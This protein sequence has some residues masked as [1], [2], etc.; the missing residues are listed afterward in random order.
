VLHD[1]QPESNS[2]TAPLVD[3]YRAW[4]LEKQGATADAQACWK[5]AANADPGYCF[6]ARLEEI[7][8]L[9][10][11][12]AANPQDTLAQYLLGNLFYDRKRY[13]EAIQLWEQSANRNPGF[14]TVWRN[15][16]VAYFNCM[17]DRLRAP[18]SAA[19]AYDRALAC[20]PHDA[21]LLYERDQLRK[22]MNKPP[23][24]RLEKL[25]DRLDLVRQ[26]DDLT[27]ELCALYNQTG[28]HDAAL[29]LLMSRHFQPWEG[30]EG[31][32]LGQYVRTRLA[33]GRSAVPENPQDA[34]MHFQAA[35][36]PPQNLGETKHLLSNQSDI[37]YWLGV[38]LE[39]AGDPS[40]ARHYWSIAASIQGDF[41]EMSVR[42]YS[43]MSYYSILSLCRLGR[44]TE[45][46]ER[47]AGL[48][49][50]SESLSKRA[51]T[52]DYFATSLPTMLLFNDDLNARQ[53]IQSKVLRAQALF[54][55][56]RGFE[57]VQLLSE[58]LGQDASHQL[59]ADLLAELSRPGDAHL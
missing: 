40:A 37:H 24:Q 15:L 22:R 39:A 46:R 45:A 6:P 10:R 21:R 54:A 43:E 56:H 35:L 11:A 30:G 38:A 42:P 12:I 33:L 25:T 17:E 44:D 19:A 16:G 5:L 13:P 55:S 1:A 49:E 29:A 4:L 3:Y 53:Q 9:R 58:V 20:D 34:R 41:Q 57:A 47:I 50:Y 51:A 31:L 14:A 2:G 32:A 36:H 27:I 48:L 8:I 28:Q 26:R 59:A 52:I 7:A 23:R 18:S